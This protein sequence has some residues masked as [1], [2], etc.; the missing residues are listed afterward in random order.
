LAGVLPSAV[1]TV[2]DVAD[3]AS[4]AVSSLATAATGAVSD[5]TG[6]IVGTLGS[7]TAESVAGDEDPVGGII[8]LGLGLATAFAG[9]G[10]GIRDLFSS[11]SSGPPPPSVSFQA[12]VT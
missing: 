6:G 12:G 8:T 4:G 2:T 3:A 11:A 10:E 5:A 1:T 7:L 9:L